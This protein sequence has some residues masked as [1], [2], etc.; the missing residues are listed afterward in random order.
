MVL[1]GITPLYPAALVWS[2]IDILILN[3]KE[4]TSQ[5]DRKEATWTVVVLLVVV[6]LAFAM[7]SR[8]QCLTPH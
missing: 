3:K 4:L 1:L 5:F 7:K 6:P 2:I 8:S